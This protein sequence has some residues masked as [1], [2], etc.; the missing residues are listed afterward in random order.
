MADAECLDS[1]SS[2]PDEEQGVVSVVEHA[3]A[4]GVAAAA[5]KGESK[6]AILRQKSHQLKLCFHRQHSY[7]WIQLAGHAGGFQVDVDPHWILKQSDALEKAALQDLQ[8]DILEPFTPKFGGLTV[9]EGVEFVQMGNLLNGFKDASV[10]DCKIGVR[11]FLEADVASSKPRLDLL[12]KMTE[13]APSAP[14]AA[15]RETGITKLRY[16][17][18]RETLSSTSALGFRIE[19]MNVAGVAESKSDIKKISSRD[20]V[21][22]TIRKFLN[23]REDIKAKFQARMHD[24]RAALE[25][26]KFFATHEVVGSSLLF[27]YDSRGKADIHIIDFGKTIP[28]EHPLH[29]ELWDASTLNHADGYL[30]G[31][32]NL[33][34]VIADA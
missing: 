12:A 11:T 2:E 34:A 10:M 30:I 31:F 3:D 1:C 20:H 17:Q 24:I 18:F 28:R 4:P 15:E 8:G 33:A 9:K 27:V 5:R 26:S 23:G 29:N 25:T 19:A 14:T 22:A 6:W 13:I 16:M 7:P 21:L 32:A